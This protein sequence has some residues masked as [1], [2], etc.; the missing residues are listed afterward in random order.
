MDT[1]HVS[2]EKKPF[3]VGRIVV[4]WGCLGRAGVLEKKR[5]ANEFHKQ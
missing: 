3:Q 4:L 1:S 5:W 2:N